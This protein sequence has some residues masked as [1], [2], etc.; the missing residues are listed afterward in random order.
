MNEERASGPNVFRD[1]GGI[2]TLLDVVIPGDRLRE[3]DYRLAETPR[4]EDLPA[5]RYLEQCI[6]AAI[7]AS[8]P[9]AMNQAIR[10]MPGTTSRDEDDTGDD[11]T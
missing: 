1:A 6:R 5:E 3:L 9:D 7:A 8:L 11:R 4:A 10:R 2:P